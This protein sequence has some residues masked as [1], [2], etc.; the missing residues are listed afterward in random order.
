METRLDADRTDL[1]VHIGSEVHG[2]DPRKFTDAD[3]GDLKRLVSERGVV[4]FRDLEL[5]IPDQVELG[6]R[7]GTL[8]RNTS[9]APPVDGFPE[10]YRVENGTDRRT[11]DPGAAWHTD[12]SFWECPPAYSMLRIETQPEVGGDTVFTSMY[13]AYETLSPRLQDFIS[14]LTASHSGAE[15]IR[16]YFGN[17]SPTE[18]MEAVHPVVRTNPTTGQRA[19]Y[20]NSAYTQRILELER[21]ESDA[22]L[23]MLFDHIA[24]AVPYQVRLSWQR[25][26]VAIWDNRC[27]QHSACW[28]YYPETRIGFRVMTV[29]E[30]PFL[31][32]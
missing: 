6:R 23:R 25:G 11:A 13:S 15:Q 31:E 19:L 21:K 26:T 8:L 17:G 24:Y 4:V 12:Q 5:P 16:R 14:T 28:D 29:G 27:V 32:S 18:G 3:I 9:A 20:V 22:L 30:E 2:K 10:V 1:T 7:L